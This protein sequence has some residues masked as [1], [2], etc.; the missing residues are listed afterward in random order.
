V[1]Q[2]NSD[3]RDKLLQAGRIAREAREK[4]IMLSEPGRRIID[5]VEEVEELIRN[6]GGMPAFPVNIGI[7]GVAAHYTP[8]SGDTHR[9]PENGVL[10]FDVGVHID[11]YIADTAA[12]KDLGGLNTALVNSSLVALNEA[13]GVIKPGVSLRFVGSVIEKAITSSGYRPITNLMGH[14]IE[15][16]NLHA[17]FSV[18]NVPDITDMPIPDEIVIAVEPFATSGRGLVVSGKMGN[19]FSMSKDKDIDDEELGSF[20]DEIVKAYNGLPFAERWLADFKNHKQLLSRLL[21]LGVIHGYQTLIEAG[22][23][24]V[25]QWEHTLIVSRDEVIATSK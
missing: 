23:G 20:R 12:T 15:R 1:L 25:S 13:L 21:R 14:S 6:R 16:Y 18:P 19:I 7:D 8:P 22:G 3:Q 24:P 10:K 4:G 17:G 5:V 9:F 11:G 2:T